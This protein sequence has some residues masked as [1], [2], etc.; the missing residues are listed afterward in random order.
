MSC[1]LRMSDGGNAELLNKWLSFV[2]E[3]CKVD[4]FRYPPS[5]IHLI[6]CGLQRYMHQNDSLVNVFDKQDVHFRGLHGTME[7][8]YQS[9]HEE[10]VGG[11]I[12]HASIITEE[13]E[14]RLLKLGILGDESPKL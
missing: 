7:S 4:G 2:M 5:S 11:E 12:R 9:L 8:V 6:L 1:V 13:E 14:E 10:E 3:V